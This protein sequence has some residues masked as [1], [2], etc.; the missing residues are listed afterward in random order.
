MSADDR[1]RLQA[2]Y[3]HRLV[4]DSDSIPEDSNGKNTRR[5][6]VAQTRE[7]LKEQSRSSS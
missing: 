5:E 1:R 7:L 6:S 4:Y 3:E 2:S